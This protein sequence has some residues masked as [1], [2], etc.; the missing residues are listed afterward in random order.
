MYD[1]NGLMIHH[2][3]ENGNTKHFEYDSRYNVIK[4]TDAKGNSVVKTYNSFNKPVTITDKK[5]NT[6][7]MTYDAR[8]NVVK[9]TYP[10]VGGIIPVETFV[11]NSCNQMTQHTDL[12]GTVTVYTYD[13]NGMPATKKVAAKMQLCTHIR[14]DFSSRRPMHAA[15]LHSMLTTQSVRSHRRPMPITRLQPTPT[16]QAVT[17]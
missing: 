16:M 7:T 2:T 8:G 17:F 3:D 5:G 12:N 13:S 9:I 14:A 15:I 1:C 10:A 6:T 4:E 11:Y